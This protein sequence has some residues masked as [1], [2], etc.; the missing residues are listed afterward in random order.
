[1]SR[2]PKDALSGRHRTERTLG[3]DGMGAVLSAEQRTMKQERRAVLAVVSH[4]TEI[5]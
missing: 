4:S 5:P 3:P 2:C 1:V